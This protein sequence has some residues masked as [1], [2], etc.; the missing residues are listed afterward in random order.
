MQRE[1]GRGRGEERARERETGREGGMWQVEM[2]GE[3]KVNQRGKERWRRE[4]TEVRRH[5]K[6]EGWK[7]GR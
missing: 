3:N 1:K 7:E 6:K 4:G 5:G 2:K